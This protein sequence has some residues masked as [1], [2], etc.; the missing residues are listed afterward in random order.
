MPRWEGRVLALLFQCKLLGDRNTP[1]S[2]GSC[3]ILD[4]LLCDIVVLALCELI[5][6]TASHFADSTN[7][8]L[9]SIHSCKR[10]PSAFHPSSISP[11]DNTGLTLSVVKW[12]EKMICQNHASFSGRVQMP[13]WSILNVIL[14]TSRGLQIYLVAMRWDCDLVCP[15]PPAFNVESYTLVHLSG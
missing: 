4:C 14:R 12:A 7:E 10:V 3:R 5:S 8:G 2:N 9:T 13:R 6:N 15:S 1:G 11:F